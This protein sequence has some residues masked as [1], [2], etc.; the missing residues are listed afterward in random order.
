MLFRIIRDNNEPTITMAEKKDI[1]L[2]KEV[3]LIMGEKE[4]RL[5]KVILYFLIPL[6]FLIPIFFIPTLNIEASKGVLLSTLVAIS[7]FLWLV[8]RMKEG[9]F[10]IPRSSLLLAGIAIP[11]VVLLSALFSQVKHVSLIGLG[12]ETGTFAMIFI[13]FLLMFLASIFFQKQSRIFYFYSALLVSF[14]V[15]LLYQIAI[16]VFNIFNIVPANI[17]P[18]LP[19]NLLGKWADLATFFGLVLMLALVGIELIS[20]RKVFKIFLIIVLGLALLSLAVINFALLWIIIGFLSLVVSVYA[21]SFGN[22][23]SGEN[24]TR[25]RT[26]PLYA[27]GV[28]IIS[29]VFVLGNGMINNLR[30][31]VPVLNI[32]TEIIRPSW[33]NTFDVSTRAL[34]EDP[35]FGVGANRFLNAWLMHKPDS[36]NPSLLWNID[37]DASVGLVPTFAVTT[38]ALGILAWI[39]F[40]GIFLYRGFT[41]VLSPSLGKIS[42]YLLFSSFLGALY[43]WIVSIFYVP[44]VAIFSLAFFM[45][46]IF[47]AVLAQTNIIKNYQFS[48]LNDPRVGFTSVLGLILLIIGTVAGG[49]ILFEK[50]VSV[51]S[52][53]RGLAANARGD[54][55]KTL[56]M[57]SRAASLSPHDLYYRNLSAINLARLNSILSQQG[58][59]Q[60]TI[61]TEFQSESG[62]AITNALRARDFDPTNYQNWITLGNAYR[63]LVPFGVEGTYDEA[64]KAYAMARTLNPKSPTIVLIQADLELANSNMQGAK[65]Y[66][67]EALNLKNNYVDAI[68]RL[69]QI[70]ANEGNLNE[71]ISAAEVASLISPM[72][73]GILFQLGFLRYKNRNYAGAV[74]AFENAL[75][76]TT[77]I[78]SLLTNTKYFLGLSYEKVGRQGDA[79]AQFNDVTKLDPTSQEARTILQNLKAGRNPLS[80]VSGGVAP[81]DRDTPPISEGES[82][83]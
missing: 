61:K 80:G 73:T 46:G 53:Q 44:N 51:A 81:E 39:V 65:D 28:L 11:A 27:F 31:Q 72:D 5:D 14:V 64:K 36:V 48:F 6:T 68:F 47:I 83:E 38:G 75:R 16:I 12:Y 69:S 3:P 40:L 24:E 25:T 30:A 15:V 76:N 62:F 60:D 29:L 74:D 52:F 19:G 9:N 32:P 22:G 42:H 21:L 57:V 55:E 54:I 56:T 63:A 70:E 82:D 18:T 8:A 43:L 37:F 26:F 78:N 49:F 2:S 41:A 20:V 34:K 10:T 59:S 1:P 23:G 7:F 17:L 13:F 79:I 33:Q 50:F 58:V 35:V 77:V 45:T 71:A 67:A 66:I 4:S